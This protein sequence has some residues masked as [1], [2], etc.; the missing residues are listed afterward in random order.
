MTIYASLHSKTVLITGGGSGIG[1]GLVRNFALQGAKVHYIDLADQIAKDSF[2]DCELKPIFHKC[3]LTDNDTLIS[4]LSQI[5]AIDVLVNNAASDDR[6][7]LEQI[8][9][10]YFDNRISVNLKHY[11][12]CARMIAP[13]M[14][15]KGSGV[16]INLG[17][18]S[19]HLGL[20]DLVLYETAKAGIE[21]MTRGLARELGPFGIRVV[22]I[23]P[24]NVKTPRQM[25]WYTSEQEQ[26]IVKAQC[27]NGRIEP[28]DV[29]KLALFLASDD[30]RYCTG[31][32]YWIDAGW[33]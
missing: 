30:A 27:L 3:D 7:S 33:R 28:V 9:S 15:A 17:S 20:E 29:A 19:W 6:H 21:G 8:D 32:E 25:K 22:T 24:G 12:T 11:F 10:D 26:E 13:Q 1:E 2:D 31:H 14:K 23:V 4:L 5:G 18:I 16:I